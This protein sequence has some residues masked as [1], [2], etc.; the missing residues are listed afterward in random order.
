MRDQ[1][2]YCY[3]QMVFN[4]RYY[5]HYSIASKRIDNLYSGFLALV[6]LASVA[7]WA[8]WEPF[9]LAWI[10][11]I[12]IAQILSGLKLLSPFSTRVSAI[13]YMLPE[14]SALINDMESTW[15]SINFISDTIDED[16]IRQSISD[17]KSRYINIE[18]KYAGKTYFPL[19]KK[20]AELADIDT[21]KYICS[22]H[23]IISL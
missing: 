4:E 12:S 19:S 7:G 10:L 20:C 13:S 22:T 2:W 11:I 3:V 18:S 15:N 5:W 9:K 21:D 17:Y 14:L 16:N 8:I 23:N 1:F 6:S